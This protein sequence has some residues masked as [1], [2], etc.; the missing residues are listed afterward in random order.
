MLEIQLVRMELIE[1]SKELVK[2]Y[3]PQ[4]TCGVRWNLR[5]GWDKGKFEYVRNT[6]H[7]QLVRMELLG[8][9]NGWVG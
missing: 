3:T 8:V 5:L 2:G 9:S 6:L 1:V 7:N 4:T